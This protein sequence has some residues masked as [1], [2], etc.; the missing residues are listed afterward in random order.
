MACTV[1]LTGVDPA[2]NELAVAQFFAPSCGGVAA[3]RLGVEASVVGRANAALPSKVG[4]L[5]LHSRAGVPA[6]LARDGQL[7]GRCAVR[8]APSRSVIQHN[9][10]LKF[11]AEAAAL[12]ARTALLPAL[13]PAAPPTPEL[14]R[15]V[16]V[17]GVD[18]AVPER[19]LRA[20]LEARCGGCIRKMQRGP[21]P[22]AAQPHAVLFLE[23]DSAEAAQRACS[24]LTGMLLR[25]GVLRVTPAK[26]VIAGAVGAASAAALPPPPAAQARVQAVAAGAPAAAQTDETDKAAPV[27]QP[28]CVVLPA[29]A[30][31]APAAPAQPPA[32]HAADAAADATSAET[33]ARTQA[34]AAELAAAAA[35]PMAAAAPHAE[36]DASEAPTA[37]A[38]AD[39]GAPVAD[40][41][42]E[43]APQA[44]K[45]D[46]AAE[47]P[48]TADAGDVS[49]DARAAG[50]TKRARCAA[51]ADASAVDNDAAVDATV[52]AADADEAAEKRAKR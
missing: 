49:T 43:A 29:A 37:Q 28:A 42:A 46:A 23:M 13:P 38:A 40:A 35:A 21:P 36:A 9:G 11:G 12:G 14:A 25:G 2:L 48:Q 30:M 22:T 17:G 51:D 31:P 8:V 10:L 24:L 45:A 3:V 44:A 5:E 41:P 47:P 19:E 7:L 16:H 52:P 1:H 4:W 50:G 6:A 26:S 20:F 18:A 27:A 32:V 34:P 33:A 39:A 15:T